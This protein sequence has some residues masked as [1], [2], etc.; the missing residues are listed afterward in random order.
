M[1]NY[2]IAAIIGVV[3]LVG[4]LQLF[5]IIMYGN[6]K[7]PVRRNLQKQSRTAR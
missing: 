2:F 4:I 3:V 5:L 6:K 1:K 7:C